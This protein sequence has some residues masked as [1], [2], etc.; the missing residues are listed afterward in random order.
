MGSLS[1]AKG[2]ATITSSYFPKT[3]DTILTSTD[4]SVSTI[5]MAKNGTNQIFDLRSLN[6]TSISEVYVKQ[7]SEG[8]A[9]SKFSNAELVE[10]RNGLQYYINTTNKVYEEIGISGASPEFFGV[11]VTTKVSPSNV[12]RRAPVAFFDLNNTSSSSLVSFPITAIPD[13]LAGQLGALS[14][15]ADSLRIKIKTSRTDLVDGYG[16][17]KLP[18]G[19]YEVLR[20]KRITYSDTDLEAY[21]KLSKSWLGIKQFIPTGQL[22]AQIRNFL[23]QDTA[24]RYHFIANNVRGTLASVLVDNTDNTKALQVTYKNK[25]KEVTATFDEV[26]PNNTRPD[27]RAMPNPA[28]DIV[29]FELSNLNAG[30]YSVR[31]YNLL[32]VVVWEEK[33]TV[34]SNNKLIRLDAT[35]L[36]KGTYLYSLRDERGRTLATKRLIILKA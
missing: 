20:E 14:T 35:N 8:D 16:T 26:S 30:N 32:G 13:S 19:D 3:G 9:F 12:V 1:F 23:G 15:F 7:A 29:N 6:A 28:V 4:F 31:I 11:N 10:Y 22:P 27:I 17:L 33:H 2:Q 24:T 36:K 21:V 34:T 5:S 18:I 25:Y